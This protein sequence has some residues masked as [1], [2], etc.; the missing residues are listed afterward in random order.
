MHQSRY[1]RRFSLRC[2]ILAVGMSAVVL[3]L[4]VPMKGQEVVERF[5]KKNPQTGHIG[6][7]VDWSTR[8]I[9]FTAGGTPEDEAATANDPRRWINDAVRRHIFRRLRWKRKGR[10]RNERKSRNR[11]S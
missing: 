10:N 6:L 9:L 7:P 5:F 2:L 11:R 1:Q 8:H 4:H 3:L